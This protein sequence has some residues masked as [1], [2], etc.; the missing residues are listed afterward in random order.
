MSNWS[1][2][3]GSHWE[4]VALAIGMMFIAMVLGLLVRWRV[5]HLIHSQGRGLPWI[6]HEAILKGLRLPTLV[7][8][9]AGAGYVGVVAAPVSGDWKILATRIFATSLILLTA[10]VVTR[11]ASN[12]VVRWAEET[13]LPYRI[14]GTIV[15]LVRSIIV[16]IL[17]VFVLGVWEIPTTPLVLVLA[18]FLFGGVVALR[19]HLPNLITYTLLMAGPSAQ[20][21][22]LVRLGTGE[23]GIVSAITW[24]AITLRSDDGSQITVPLS[25]YTQSKVTNFG[26]PI[27]ETQRRFHRA[28]PFVTPTPF[29]PE[30]RA[31][32]RDWMLQHPLREIYHRLFYVWVR[33]GM[34]DPDLASDLEDLNVSK[35]TLGGLRS[36]LV[37]LAERR[38]PRDSALRPEVAATRHDE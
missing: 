1:V 26:R 7:V 17:L 38:L 34:G 24:Q 9:A 33:D 29:L 30:T 37:E 19:S 23:E 21:G 14:V 35:F 3:L 36:T 31:E 20:K 18:V 5:S 12:M 15:W 27:L 16:F 28:V 22:D 32:L 10:T 11:L 13:K 6:T 2:W 25:I 4:G 8:I